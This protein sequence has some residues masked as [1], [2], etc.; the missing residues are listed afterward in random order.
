MLGSISTLFGSMA[1]LWLLDLLNNCLVFLQK[2]QLG[3]PKF[4]P[5]KVI[6]LQK[7]PDSR[8]TSRHRVCLRLRAAKGPYA[9]LPRAGAAL[10]PAGHPFDRDTHESAQEPLETKSSGTSGCVFRRSGKSPGFFAMSCLAELN[11]CLNRFCYRVCATYVWPTHARSEFPFCLLQNWER[12]SS[13][14]GFHS[15]QTTPKGNW[16]VYN[17][18]T[19]LPESLKRRGPGLWQVGATPSSFN[20]VSRFFTTQREVVSVTRCGKM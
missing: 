3:F 10:P 15:P 2:L 19:T 4:N 6:Y 12:N 14:P 1:S 17:S 7:A 9:F 20:G 13:T 11:S 18:G 5:Q 16:V 8:V